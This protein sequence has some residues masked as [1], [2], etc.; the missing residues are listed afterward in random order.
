MYRGGM[1]EHPHD[2]TL[3]VTVKISAWWAV[4]TVPG[5]HMNNDKKVWSA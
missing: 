5:F 4:M 2:Y 1:S 3:L